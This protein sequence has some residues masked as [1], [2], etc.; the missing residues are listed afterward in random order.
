MTGFEKALGVGGLLLD[1]AG[2]L[3]G[4][5]QASKNRRLRRQEMAMAQGQFDAQMDESVQRRVKDAQAAGIHPLFAMGASVGA[6][7]TLQAGAT[8]APT[9]SAMGDALTAMASRLGII[10][11]RRSRANLDDAQADYYRHLVRKETQAA[12]SQGRDTL[13]SGGQVTTYP[14]PAEQA[15]GQVQVLPTVVN[16]SKKGSP[17]IRAGATQLFAEVIGSDGRRRT[18][19]NPDLGWDEPWHPGFMSYL[20]DS[21]KLRLA[22]MAEAASTVPKAMEIRRLESEL[23]T[24]KRARQADPT[25]EKYRAMDKRMKSLA[26]RILRL[27]N[28]GG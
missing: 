7:P 3:L 17:H 22:D 19:L 8:Q 25:G 20:Y 4:A 27:L 28:S 15:A 13:N 6:S 2:G 5:S 23:E 16:P 26:R 21:A 24:L 12:A 18:V 11:E 1:F 9:G 14:Y 10:A